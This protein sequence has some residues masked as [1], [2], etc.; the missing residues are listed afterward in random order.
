MSYYFAIIS[1]TDTPLFELTF[2]TS[3]AGG[4]GVA[5]FRNGETSRYMNQFI[6]HAALDVV[7]EVQ[8]LTPNMWLK[9]I[10]S[11]APTNSHVSCMVTG[12]NHRFMLLHQPTPTP[13][14]SAGSRASTISS[15]SIPHNPT[16]PQT[17]DA[18]RQFMI[19]CIQPSTT[20]SFTLEKRTDDAN[21][22]NWPL[23]AQILLPLGLL[24]IWI[25]VWFFVTLIR[26]F[27]CW[28]KRHRDYPDVE[29]QQSQKA[30]S[31]Q[32]QIRGY[33]PPLERPNPA[34]WPLP[35]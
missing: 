22:V 30:Q 16:A 34:A 35:Q 14:S 31:N 3:K 28:Q 8:W 20:D 23:W 33:Q 29:K 21:F 19:I 6:V 32:P 27:S 15:N 24:T 4:D 11:Y 9:V 1:P 13:T 17:E 26:E 25:P 2:G 10:D 5:R 12:S 18:I 7:E